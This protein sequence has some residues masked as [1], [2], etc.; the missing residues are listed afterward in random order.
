M[1]DAPMGQ[2]DRSCRF[3]FAHPR[4][5][6]ALVRDILGTRI[7]GPVDLSTLERVPDSYVTDRL[8][9]RS[10]DLV[11]QLRRLDGRRLYILLEFQ[12]RPD[13]FMAVRVT[14]YKGLLWESLIRRRD[15]SRGRKVPEVLA[16]VL[17]TG[18]RLWRSACDLAELVD[19]PPGRFRPSLR[20]RLIDQQRIPSRR[21]W[22]LK[23]PVAALFL[24]DRRLAPAERRRALDLLSESLAEPQDAELRR[25]FLI[26]IRRVLLPA[27]NL[28]EREIPA[29]PGREEF[30]AMLRDN[31]YG[32]GQQFREEGV[33]EGVQK[34]VREGEAGLLLRLLERKFGPLSETTRARVHKASSA[35]RL[36]WADRVLTATTLA[37]VFAAE[38]RAS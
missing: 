20:Y 36:L 2:H 21:L 22:R 26:W 35:R 3:L 32:W 31:A 27:D 25:A 10:S 30:E 24:L 23:S 14:T 8:D 33:R 28:D 11:W 12:S 15:P 38:R 34:G 1:E 16:I 37:E 5:V 9:A 19:A 4:L 17:Y 29:L 13:R 18:D 6:A 7:T